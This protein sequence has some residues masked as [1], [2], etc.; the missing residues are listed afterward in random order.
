MQ[1]TKTVRAYTRKTRTGKSVQVRQ[2]TAKYDAADFAKEASKR[3]GAGSEY[4]KMQSE[5]VSADYGFTPDEYREWY[6]WDMIDDP[7]NASAK[8]VEGILKQSLGA[9]GY[10]KYFNE[11]SDTYTAKGHSRAFKGLSSV[12]P[13]ETPKPK[14][15]ET[16]APTAAKPAP[17]APPKS[18]TPK[19]EEP[20]L[21]ALFYIPRGKSGPLA[22]ELLIES[23]DPK[24]IAKARKWAL[25]NGG[26]ITREYPIAQK[27]KAPSFVAAV[28]KTTIPTREW[29]HVVRENG[30]SVRPLSNFADNLLSRVDKAGVKLPKTFAFDNDSSSSTN[31]GF[32]SRNAEGIRNI[33]SQAKKKKWTKHEFERD[34]I[35]HTA[36]KSPCGTVRFVVRGNNEFANIFETINR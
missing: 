35:K 24:K 1:K 11:M 12:M 2:H 3:A 36:Y 30:K 17:T 33:V 8:K 20:K 32:V 13:K 5:S 23:G 27:V 19:Q 21:G 15:V 31:G 9:R 29:K 4:A 7:D 6:H 28:T 26:T 10:K 25:E 16:P 34:G 14:P 22:E 18:V